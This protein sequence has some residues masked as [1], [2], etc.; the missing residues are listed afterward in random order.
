MTSIARCCQPVPGDPVV[1]YITRGRG[2]TIHR[3]DCA[4]VLRWQSEDNQRLLQVSWGRK[5]DSRYRADIQIKAFNR[6]DLIRDISA[7]M[8]A[9]EVNVSDISS[10]GTDRDDVVLIRLQLRVRDY[11][12]LSELL[13]RLS[14]IRNVM[15]ARRLRD[16]AA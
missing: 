13:S 14:S 3:D 11:E 5:S 15:E 8:T 7:V 4:N 2:V 16:E 1:G 12:Q 9:A 6:R 10:S